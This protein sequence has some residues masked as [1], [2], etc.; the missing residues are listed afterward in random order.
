MSRRFYIINGMDDVNIKR[1]FLNS[2]PKPIGR[3]NPS[4]DEYP[5]N[6]F[7]SS[8]IGRNLSTYAYCP[9]KALQPKEVPFRNGEDS[10][11]TQGQ[12]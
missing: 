4:N 2:L 5:N 6:N 7:E 3:Q 11:Y 12:L 1:T 9:G 8:L 10:Q